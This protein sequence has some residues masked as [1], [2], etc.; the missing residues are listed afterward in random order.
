MPFNQHLIRQH[1]AKQQ[2][3]LAAALL[4]ISALQKNLRSKLS[5]CQDTRTRHECDKCKSVTLQVGTD[6]DP[7]AVKAAKDNAALN[8]VGDRLVALQCSPSVQVSSFSLFCLFWLVSTLLFIPHV[9]YVLL[10]IFWHCF[11]YHSYFFF[12]LF[13]PFA[14]S[15]FFLLLLWQSASACTH[16]LCQVWPFH[17]CCFF[18]HLT[19]ESF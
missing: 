16:N 7:L 17:A 13:I 19:T 1:W 2:G 11:F 9:P 18:A 8:S 3:C 14:L 6:V 15:T 4:V 5:W 10:L 12:F